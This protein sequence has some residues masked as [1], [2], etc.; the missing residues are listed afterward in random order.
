MGGKWRGVLSLYAER[1]AMMELL[2]RQ[3]GR[4]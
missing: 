1:C 2:N 4:V 3:Q